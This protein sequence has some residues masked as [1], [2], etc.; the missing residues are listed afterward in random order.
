MFNWW[1]VVVKLL[2]LVGVLVVIGWVV[3]LVGWGGW[4]G[5]F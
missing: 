1:V 4:C 2:Y 5:G 3:V